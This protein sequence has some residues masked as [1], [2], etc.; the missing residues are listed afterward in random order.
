VGIHGHVPP[1]ASNVKG[2]KGY[3]CGATRAKALQARM[4]FKS[5]SAERLDLFAEI[6]YVFVPSHLFFLFASL[7]TMSRERAQF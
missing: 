4:A 7:D 6:V 1:Q 5:E 3:V 2:C